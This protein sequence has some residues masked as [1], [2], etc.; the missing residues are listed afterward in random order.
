[1]AV[2]CSF[3]ISCFS[4][5]L[6]RYFLN[7][8]ICLCYYCYRLCIYIPHVLF[9]VLRSLRIRIFSVPFFIV[10]LCH[11]FA[12]S[13]NIHVS[14]LLFLFMMMMLVVVLLLLLFMVL[15][16]DVVLLMLLFQYCAIL[17]TVDSILQTG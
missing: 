6:L 17:Q 7:G 10:F 14:L 1:M 4:G 12:T 13:I 9:S 11:E 16:L 15:F 3:S 8:F 5:R 2:F